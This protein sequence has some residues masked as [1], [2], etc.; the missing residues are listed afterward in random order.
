MIQYNLYTIL[1]AK[2][3]DTNATIA[4]LTILVYKTV[5]IIAVLQNLSSARQTQTMSLSQEK[6]N[7][8]S[9][10]D[11]NY[12]ITA[13]IRKHTQNNP[14]PKDIIN[15]C[16]YFFYFNN[17]DE[18]IEKLK[19]CQY[20][21]S[22]QISRLCSKLKT[23]LMEES[24]IV[25]I[26]LNNQI[27]DDQETNNT[28]IIVGCTRGQFYGLVPCIFGKYGYPN[29]T[30]QSPKYLFLGGYISDY[31]HFNIECLSLLLC[32]KARYPSNITLL[33]GYSEIAQ[34]VLMGKVY[35]EIKTKY[36]TNE[37]VANVTKQF[38]EIFQWLP[39]CSVI[40]DKIFVVHGGMSPSINTLDE[41]AVMDRFTDPPNDGALTDLLFSIP[42][43]AD[44]SEENDAWGLSPRGAGYYFNKC[45]VDQFCKRNK[46]EMIIRAGFTPETIQ[47]GY[48]YQW[49]NK[50]LTIESTPNIAYRNDNTACVAIVDGEC[51]VKLESFYASCKDK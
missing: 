47:T 7:D 5:D 14:M 29:D 9:K 3:I 22:I 39:L 11:Q 41:I 20:I 16:F 2:I 23:I 48:E 4:S 37:D 36:N 44:Q 10:E 27:T 51:N 26:D 17:L 12:I 24:N 50:L 1:T 32:L 28:L 21:T 8:I 49:E 15:L 40:N 35:D 6:W 31:G 34:R 33:R 30:P 43:P 19:N 13:F 45:V 25:R 38:G 42:F 46:I 18:Y